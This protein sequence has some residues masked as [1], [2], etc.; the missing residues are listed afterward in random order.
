[1][2]LA[3]LTNFARV[4]ELGNFSKAAKA[5]GIVQ[6]ALSR[7]VKDLELEL[8][9]QLLRRRPW[10]VEPT[11]AGVSLASSVR[12]IMADL[13]RARAEVHAIEHEPAGVVNV[14]IVT[15]LAQAFF[16]PLLKAVI[17]KYPQ[18]QLVLREM[19]LE[20]I[21]SGLRSGK[22]ELAITNARIEPSD[23]NMT[24]L[25]EDDWGVIA[26]SEYLSRFGNR[27]D[28]VLQH[29]GLVMMPTLYESKTQIG[30][31]LNNAD[32]N[33]LAQ[34]DSV[35]GLLDVVAVQDCAT[36]L[37][38]SVAADAIANGRLAFI[39]FGTPMLRRQVS[40]AVS[41]SMAYGKAVMAVEQEIRSVT[42][43]LADAMR[44]ELWDGQANNW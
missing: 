11:T 37:P 21:Q 41:S 29:A 13:D 22:L 26:R 14:G 35:A 44:W 30:R 33:I 8:G 39:S 42:T 17:E 1:M 34:I 32:F 15:T 38:Y 36:I 23:L 6:P 4:V 27:I 43:E 3:Q 31:I 9:V 2:K 18:V 5:I 16:A 24:P 7:Q 19:S 40:L 20:K 12:R 28:T 25:F 10:G